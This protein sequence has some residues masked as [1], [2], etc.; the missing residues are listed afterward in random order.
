MR[1]SR[2]R[3]DVALRA[4][5]V[6]GVQEQVLPGGEVVGADAEVVAVPGQH[7]QVEEH[8]LAG[9]GLGL[10]PRRV[11]ARSSVRQRIGYCWPS[12]VR[13]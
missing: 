3:I 13:L 9:H 10:G 1:R 5:V 6:G 12:S 8:L 4:V 2:T 7:V 11:V